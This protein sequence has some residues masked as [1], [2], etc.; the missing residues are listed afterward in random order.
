MTNRRPI[1]IL[2]AAIVA[3]GAVGAL[4]APTAGGKPT[5]PKKLTF[6]LIGEV[7][8][9]AV[10]DNGA[11]G[12]SPG[13]V[14]VFS[15]AIYDAS[16]AREVGR[17]HASCTRMTDPDGGQLC[18]GVFL[19]AKGQITIQGQ[20]PPPGVDSHPLIVTG[21]SGRYRGVRGEIKVTHLSPIEDRFAFKLRR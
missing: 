21:G 12:N 1:R 8:R 10:V 7:D 20:E 4:V 14:L 11:P 17:S 5:K 19:L 2:V 16:G 3:V 6:T 9:V 18:Q 13:D 15:Q